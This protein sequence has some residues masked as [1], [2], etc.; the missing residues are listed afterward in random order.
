MWKSLLFNRIILPSSGTLTDYRTVEI[1]YR[2][3][4]ITHLLEILHQLSNFKIRTITEMH[5][6]TKRSKD[7]VNRLSNWAIGFNWTVTKNEKQNNT[8]KTLTDP[9]I[10]LD[11]FEKPGKRERHFEKFENGISRRGL[12]WLE[13]EIITPFYCAC[14]R[15]TGDLLLCK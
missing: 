3:H 12:N 4:N 1:P 11:V 7:L 10:V 13:L 5:N 6:L 8:K 9:P 14:A 15:E 2:Y